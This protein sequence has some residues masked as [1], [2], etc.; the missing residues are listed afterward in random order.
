[1]DNGFLQQLLAR[2]EHQLRHGNRHGAI[3]SL[4]RLLG[5]E[6]EHAYAHALLALCLLH[7]KRLHAASHEI[8]LAIQ[9]EPELPFIHYVNGH[10]ALAHRKFKAAEDH[11]NTALGLQPDAAAFQLGLA[12]VYD[13]LGDQTRQRQAL[14]QALALDPSDDDCHAQLGEFHLQRG[15][16]APA[17][18]CARDALAIN[19]DSHGAIILMGHILLRR[20]QILE[21]RE[22]SLWALQQDPSSVR[23]LHLMAHIKART[24]P[25]LGLWWRFN[26]MMTRLGETRLILAMILMFVVYRVGSQVLKDM[27]LGTAAMWLSFAWLAFVIYTWVGPALFQRTLAK[28]LAGFKLRGD[29]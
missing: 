10:I 2:A 6:P 9:L 16:L 19:P 28:E 1:M 5:H 7:Q 3:N 17:E 8:H 27:D 24:N 23:A 29:F 12:Q 26:T 22:H 15:N 21:A 18:A 11:F 4:K 20:G 13:L 14:E 25:F